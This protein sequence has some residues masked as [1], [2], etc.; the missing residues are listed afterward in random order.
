MKLKLFFAL[1]I[2][3]ISN[4]QTQ[5]GQ[6]ILDTN[7][8]IYALALSENG[9]VLA[10]SGTDYNYNPA[11]QVFSNVSGNWTQVGQDLELGRALLSNDGSILAIISSYQG[12]G[13]AR[14]YKNMNN[15][16]VQTG[17]D[18][19]E[20]LVS[21]YKIALSGD[22]SVL[23]IA[24]KIGPYP[25]NIYKNI[26]GTW[27]V[28]GT[29]TNV[30]GSSICLS[31]DGNTLAAISHPSNE[32]SIFKHVNN[33]WIQSTPIN[34]NSNYT[35]NG[36]RMA[37]SSDGNTIAVSTGNTIPMNVSSVNVFRYTN[38][39]WAQMGNSI[40]SSKGALGESYGYGEVVIAGSG[41]VVALGAWNGQ[42]WASGV[43]I[44][45]YLQGNWVKQGE[46]IDTTITNFI[47][48]VIAISRDGSSL[49][50]RKN[51]V[52]SPKTASSVNANNH[53]GKAPSGGVRVYD[54]SGILSSD[55]FVLENFKVYP[56]PT[57]DILNIE[58]ENS[59]VL[60]KVF[61]YNTN[62]QLIKENFAEKIINV[63]G[64]AKGIYYVQVV[65]NQGKATK[66]VV[67]K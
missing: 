27:T 29:I 28:T 9:N 48:E 54:I 46:I 67:V 53:Q 58:L 47:H 26:S 24:P 19:L 10:V 64:F 40:I 23:A 8:E 59:L 16:W 63:S 5:I 6:D 44:F 18:I 20:P 62:G 21:D 45:E 50:L 33:N 60:E 11:T 51:E 34:L 30:V 61:I 4:A 66:K 55:T 49:A 14:V 57:T 65:T 22:G 12:A 39:T 42:T 2:A 37:M 36:F 43:D 41:N 38:N 15:N 56:N 13:L 52:L 31:E 1:L 25:W 32:I 35:S 3:T 17:Q 7:R